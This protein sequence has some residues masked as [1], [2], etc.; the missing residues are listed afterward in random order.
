[1]SSDRYCAAVSPGRAPF[2]SA[3]PPATNG[4]A[5]L[6]PSTTVKPEGSYRS[7]SSAVVCVAVMKDDPTATRSGLMD[8]STFG[9]LLE[10]SPTP[11]G[12]EEIEA[13]MKFRV[14]VALG[15]AAI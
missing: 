3:A 14:A 13:T 1:M 8:P 2:N 9:P 7:P 6:V 11:S 12:E 10:K 4:A 15:L 5:K